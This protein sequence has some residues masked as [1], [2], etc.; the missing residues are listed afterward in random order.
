MCS[1][2]VKDENLKFGYFC[3]TL[4]ANGTQYPY[5]LVI[6]DE[7]AKFS[8]TKL[9]YWQIIC[10]IS[11]WYFVS[12]AQEDETFLT[13]LFTQL[14]DEATDESRLTELVSNICSVCVCVCVCICVCLCVYVCV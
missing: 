12:T 11:M 4:F 5:I 8:S 7:F 6:L 1:N 14:C 10:F 13:Q 2:T 9:I 3:Q